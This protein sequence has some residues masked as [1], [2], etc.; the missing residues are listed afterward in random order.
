[1]S[2]LKCTNLYKASVFWRRKKKEKIYRGNNLEKQGGTQL[3]FCSDNGPICE[4]KGCENP[5]KHP[6]T[7]ARWIEK[8]AFVLIT[9][10]FQKDI[11]EKKLDG[12]KYENSERALDGFTTTEAY[13]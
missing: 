7:F 8:Y 11:V 1:M 3:S 12:G 4:N 13:M 10:N 9:L 6:R 5:Q 2:E